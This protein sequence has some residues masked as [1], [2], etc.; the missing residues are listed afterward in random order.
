MTSKN[1]RKHAATEPDAPS[2]DLE[3]QY[4]SSAP[5]IVDVPKVS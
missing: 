4:T 3:K 2:G 1:I 5:R